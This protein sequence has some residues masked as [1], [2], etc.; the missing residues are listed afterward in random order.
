M[1]ATLVLNQIF[2]YSFE[3]FQHFAILS[4]L[5]I[6]FIVTLKVYQYITY[7]WLPTG[8]VP[9]HVPAPQVQNLGATIPNL[10]AAAAGLVQAQVATSVSVQ[11]PAVEEVQQQP[12]QQQLQQPPQL[13]QQTSP[14][15][16]VD[17]TNDVHGDSGYTEEQQEPEPE[18]AEQPQEQGNFHCFFIVI[19]KDKTIE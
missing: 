19:N 11:Q 7:T 1:F 16:H 15:Q 4:V 3:F 8:Q 13:Q 14:P 10:Q 9:Q 6:L 18:I 2:L 12:P 5:T 17:S